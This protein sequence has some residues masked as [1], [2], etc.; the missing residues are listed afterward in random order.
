MGVFRDEKKIA[1]LLERIG[2][3]ETP[4]SGDLEERMIS[5]LEKIAER[6]SNTLVVTYT[7]T[8]EQVEGAET[9][10][11]DKTAEEIYSA[12]NDGK[13]IVA[14]CPEDGLRFELSQVAKENDDEDFS[15]DL[16]FY[17]IGRANDGASDE[18]DY[19]ELVH[20]RRI[21]IRENEEVEEVTIT[22]KSYTLA[23][24]P[25]T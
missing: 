6:G 20:N 15:G 22:L 21:V 3:I 24:I 18:I 5:G 11:C 14:V 16:I 10:T 13:N 8:G 1:E 4:V 12:Y 2:G 23:T 7:P 17:S 9:Y 25:A 19:I